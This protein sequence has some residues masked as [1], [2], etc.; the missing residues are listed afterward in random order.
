MLKFFKDEVEAFKVF[1]LDGGALSCDSEGFYHGDNQDILATLDVGC[2]VKGAT[3]QALEA[4]VRKWTK[5]FC[6][7]QINWYR[8]EYFDIGSKATT[9]NFETEHQARMHVVNLAMQGW[10]D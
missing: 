7:E 2:T 6:L 8:T 5:E 3:I 10:M 1:V 9:K 4:I